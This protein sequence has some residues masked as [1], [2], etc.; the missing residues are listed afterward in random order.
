MSRCYFL[1]CLSQQPLTALFSV[2]HAAR[3]EGVLLQLPD[4]RTVTAHGTASV[5]AEVNPLPLHRECIESEHGIGEQT[6]RACQVL[7]AL[8]CL[9]SAEHSRYATEHAHA[10]ARLHVSVCRWFGKHTSVARRS[11]D[12]CH[13]LSR[14]AVDASHAERLV[15]HDASVIDELLGGEVVSA[16]QYEVVPT[17]NVESI[18]LTEEAVV[19]LNCDVGV[20][21]TYLPFGTQ[22]LGLSDVGC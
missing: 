19:P 5:P 18:V 14:I 4:G 6:A 3:L 1:Y 17:D 11:A 20:Q 7:N 22:C 2:L 16:V 8:R 12:V 10:G 9:Y 21:F 13:H 15:E